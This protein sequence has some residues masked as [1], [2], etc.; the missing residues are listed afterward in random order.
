MRARPADTVPSPPALFPMSELP[1]PAAPRRLFTALF[2]DAAACAAVDAAR[3]RWAGLPPGRP[4]AGQL[5]RGAADHAQRGSVGA[6]ALPSR[7]HPAPE[8]MHLTLQFFGQVPAPTE[9]AWRQAL[10]ALRFD[11]FEIVLDRAELWHAPS[12]VIAVLRP[13]P[14]PALDALH[15]ATARLARQAG[16]PA[17]TQG[18]KP[19]LTTLRRAE[20]TELA[21]LRQPI[22]WTARAID[23]IW[24]DLH[25]QPPRYHRLGRFPA[26]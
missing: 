23:L 8:R 14:N 18:F 4:K 2:P 3:R 12:G 10:A 22:G 11:P 5:P 9:Q 15:R 13:A 24:S 7:L 1:L 20:A 16:L 19:H 26:P 6:N 17:A 25:A 21:P